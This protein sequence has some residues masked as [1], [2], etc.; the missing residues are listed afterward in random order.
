MEASIS[1]LPTVASDVL[2]RFIEVEGRSIHYRV[3]GSGPAVVMLHDS[4]RSSRLHLETIRHLSRRFRV[5]ALDTPGYGNSQPLDREQLEISD[6][7]R[8]LGAVLAALGLSKAPL[9]ATHTSAKIALEYAARTPLPARLILDGLSIPATPTDPAFIDRYMRPFRTEETGGYLAAE[10][11]RMRD[12]VR[13][14]PWFEQQ[15]GRRIPTRLPD[16]AWTSDYVIDFFSA[17]PHYAS[18]YGAA[19]RYDPMPALQSVRCPTIVAAKADDVLFAYLDKVPV[20]ENPCL[21]VEKLSAEREAWLAWLEEAFASATAG[22]NPFSEVAPQPRCGSLYVDLD[23]GPLRLHRAGPADERPLLIL[24]APTTLHAL[25]WQAALSNRATLVPELP[26]FGES[27]PLPDPTVSATADALAAM[28]EALGLREV[29]LLATSFATPLGASLA[30]RHPDMVRRVILDGCFDVGDD[31]RGAFAAAL[32]PTFPFDP[33]GGHIHRYWH[34]LRDAEASW[35]WFATQADARRSLPPLLEAEGLHHALLGLLKQP[36]HY[37]DIA[38]AVCDL[39]RQQRYPLFSQAA[40]LFER[41]DDPGYG[42]AAAVAARLPDVLLV[43]RP[44]PSE[45]AARSVAAFL[46]QAPVAPLDEVVL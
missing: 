45:E 2:R 1:G 27:A 3:A 24:S 17:G 12:M 11:T 20:E 43:E 9:Y 29:D 32:C 4:P 18:A 36:G 31:K 25:R 30:T 16:E 22:I 15:P 42:A 39:T 44:D 46:A 23:H 28:L 33:G 10:W 37:G 41:A 35:P 8:A 14:F 26:G 13:W 19:M 6:F 40:L 5:F 34:M 21:S 7:A 38:R